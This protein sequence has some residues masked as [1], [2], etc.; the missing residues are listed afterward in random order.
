MRDPHAVPSSGPL[1]PRHVRVLDVE[2]VLLD[3]PSI[4]DAAVLAHDVAGGERVMVAYAVPA[5]HGPFSAEDVRRR[6]AAALAPA[7]GPDVVVELRSM[8]LTPEGDVD[9]VALRDVA[10]LDETLVARWERALR[11]VAGVQDVAVMVEER[12]EPAAVRHMSDLLPEWGDDAENADAAAAAQAAPAAEVS[13]TSARPAFADGGP[14]EIPAEAPRTLGE[15]L[16]RTAERHGDR[17]LHLVQPDGAVI[18]MSYAELLQRARRILAG[19]RAMGFVPGDRAILQIPD[20]D[21]HFPTFWACVLGGIVPVTVAVPPAHDPKNAVTRKLV[22]AWQ[23]LG[24]PVILAGGRVAASVRSLTDS[25]ELGDLRVAIVGELAAHPPTDW[26]HPASPADVAF[27]QLSS[28]STGVSKC[29]QIRH[30]GVVSHVHAQ[31]KAVGNIQSDIT[32]NW[33]PMDHVVP[34][35]TYHIKDTYMGIE[36]VQLPGPMVLAQPLVWLDHLERFGATHTW[37][38]NFAFKMLT[39]ALAEAGDRR[40]DLSRVKS[41][42]NAG[43]QVTLPVIQAFLERVAPFGAGPTTMQP[44]FG[45]AEV[46]TI[47]TH[48]GAYDGVTSVHR[49]AKDSLQSVLRPARDHEPAVVFVDCGPIMAGVQVRVVDRGNQLLREDMLGRIQIK[50][51]V[52]TPGY[53]NN[54]AANEETFVGDGWLNTGDLGF[55]HD[56]RLAITGREKELIIINGA[57]FYCYEIEDVAAGVR[58]VLPTFA[59]ACGVA[60]AVSGTEA[61]AFFFVPDESAGV[62]LAE[63]VRAIRRTLASLIGLSP[64][65]VVPVR[66]EEFPKTT[67]GK[68]QRGHLKTALLTGKFRQALHD[69]D[70]RL[71]NGSTVPEWFYRPTWRRRRR[72]AAAKET[73]AVTVLFSDD[74]GVGAA[75][76]EAWRAQGA[77]VVTVTGGASLQRLAHDAFQVRPGA[78][79][80][81]EALLREVGPVDRVVHAWSV[82]GRPADL[83]DPSSIDGALERGVYS[84]ATVMRATVAAQAGRPTRLIVVSSHGQRVAADDAVVPERGPLAALV[85]TLASE[86]PWVSCQ[87]IDVDLDDRDAAARAIL[88]EAA[89]A[90]RDRIV[91][92]RRGE[93]FV[94]RL[95]PVD[96][97]ALPPR[98]SPFTRGGVYLVT[99][100]VGGVGTEVVKYLRSRFQARVVAVGRSP[101]DSAS[102]AASFRELARLPGESIYVQADAADEAGLRAAAAAARERWGQDLDGAVHL[103]GVFQERPLAEESITGL[104]AAMRSK[105][106]GTLALHKLLRERPGRTLVTFSSAYGYL[107]GFGAGAYASANAFLDAFSLSQSPA[108]ATPVYAIGWALWDGIGMSRGYRIEDA[109]R[110]RGFRL[111]SRTPAL[112]SLA[113][114]LQRAVPHILVGLDPTGRTIRSQIEHRDRGAE[115]LT[116]YWVGAQDAFQHAQSDLQAPDRLGR[117]SEIQLHAIDVLPRVAGGMVDRRALLARLRGVDA[118]PV[119]PSTHFEQVVAETWRSALNLDNVS[120]NDNFFD[121]GGTSLLAAQVAGRLRELL[122]RNI[123]ANEMFQ[124]PTIAAQAAHLSGDTD[125]DAVTVAESQSRGAARRAS[126]RRLRRST[127]SA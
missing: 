62:D 54:P 98:P 121:L 19:L 97:A 22:N 83:D 36:Q 67:S 37:A 64:R 5:A 117:L 26:S 81:V 96:L 124:F 6:V 120:I 25:M 116:A 86:V 119:A 127:P 13:M 99:G 82:G 44:A 122:Q 104:R 125:G 15:A 103:A 75:A 23:L 38:P 2:R 126:A 90:A 24:R 17:R 65:Y 70:V 118:A 66:R 88:E 109:A 29:I 63:T 50:G 49:V 31:V 74:A 115:R 78:L 77:R 41:F 91:A 95:E 30:G 52:V 110:A 58:G 92:Y 94:A 85:R 76:G 47:M 8:P 7:R 71:E 34:I 3:Q 59:A 113:A 43:E 14:L 56:G 35:L 101:E 27:Y 68:I 10:L 55:L 39:D 40:W 57:N 102:V 87:S 32:L 12:R 1:A 45:M 111:M 93:R 100:G 11:G 114:V 123:D 48:D 79:D 105:V 84:V 72:A 33:L 80:D 20:L 53:L 61:L 28:G 108:G 18:V 89:T 21:E 60:D 16:V 42:V 112:N 107:G 69:I 46:C 9:E 4:E 106:H 51:A 73:T